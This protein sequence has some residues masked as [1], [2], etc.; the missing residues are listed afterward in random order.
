MRT[1]EELDRLRERA[2]SLRREGKS[3]REIK[4]VLG[5]M[6]NSTLAGFLRG[7]PPPD[8]TR[9][10]NAKDELRTMARRL[11]SLGLDYDEIVA[12]LGV[13]KSS[14]S[15]WVRDLPR[16]PRLSVEECR[17][18]SAEGSRR[19]WE[20]E[21][22]A[23]EARLAGVA[24]RA[25][26]EV[27]DMTDREIVIAGAIAYW[28]EGSKSKPHRRLDRVVFIN[29][30]PALIGFFL[31]FLDT[32]DVPREALVFRVYIHETADVESAQ[33][34]WLGLTGAEPSQFRRP[35][36][37]RHNPKTIRKN[38]GEGYLGCLRID[39]RRSSDLY[40]RIEGWATAAMLGPALSAT[41]A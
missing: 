13:S 31:K 8:W 41:S 28:C 21:R 26:A 4:A 15:L 38:V 22:L 25:A 1:K 23:R 24:G 2:I 30:D 29:S 17:K 40:R 10:P 32:A 27:G 16:P 37:K 35:V 7:V 36:L 6:S 20:A 39:V 12:S 14:V 3:R 9:R 33:R 19:Y 18:R 5:P 34:F 11:R